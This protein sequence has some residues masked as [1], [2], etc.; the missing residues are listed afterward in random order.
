MKKNYTKDLDSVIRGLDGRVLNV[1]QKRQTDSIKELRILDSLA[2]LFKGTN[3]CTALFSKDNTVNVFYNPAPLKSVDNEFA[4][5]FFYNL[6]TIKTNGEKALLELQILNIKSL[7]HDLSKNIVQIQTHI[8]PLNKVIIK[9]FNLINNNIDVVKDYINDLCLKVIQEH[10]N[11][12]DNTTVWNKYISCV[13]SKDIGVILNLYQECYTL[14]SQ[15]ESL[16]AKK[17]IRN[18]K[19]FNKAV[20]YYRESELKNIEFPT[21]VDEN[22]DDNVRLHAELQALEALSSKA[23]TEALIGISKL[24]CYQCDYTFKIFNDVNVTFLTVRGTHGKIYL[25]WVFPE[26][27]QNGEEI[28][29]LFLEN[30]KKILDDFHLFK[31][32]KSILDDPNNSLSDIEVDFN[33]AILK[34]LITQG[35]IEGKKLIQDNHY[36]E[37][38]S[39]YVDQENKEKEKYI[40]YIKD[41][42]FALLLESGL[43]TKTQLY[44]MFGEVSKYIQDKQEPA[45]DNKTIVQTLATI[46]QGQL[47]DLPLKGFFQQIIESYS[48]QYDLKGLE[49]YGKEKDIGYI[50]S[51]FGKYTLNALDDI[52][53]LRINDLQLKDIKILQC[54]FINQDYNNI[55]DLLTKISSTKEQKILVPLNLFNKHAVG[56]IFE[57]SENNIIQVKYFDPLNKS[58]NPELKQI[59]INS[60]DSKANFQQIAVEQ[61]KYAN[62][63]AEL[64]ENFILYLTGNRVSQEKAVELHSKLVENSL[65]GLTINNTCLLFEQ[66]NYDKFQ[67]DIFLSGNH[68]EE[69]C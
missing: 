39:S 54:V 13:F 62:C 23:I 69:L 24:C 21:V 33:K 32:D 4:S 42:I 29:K 7:I 60:L 11:A 63:G 17:I 45:P 25:G 44:S 8:T 18:F 1:L 3:N 41:K 65:L 49:E 22:G 26:N 16:I 37:Q 48:T 38:K 2:R 53:T 50:N 68:N 55:P 51:Y 64:I 58:I 9:L 30:C 31:L 47:I 19:D 15:D 10:N 57:R 14:A 20:K 34:D 66:S 61:Q 35:D 59:M 52:L 27:I 5:Q 40:D 28:K 12:E 6:S 67:P 43:N 36:E 46:M 56:L